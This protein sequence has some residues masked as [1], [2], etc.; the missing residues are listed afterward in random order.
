ME[1]QNAMGLDFASVLKESVTRKPID[2]H[3]Q[4]FYPAKVV[5]NKD[6]DKLGRCRVMV[7]GVYDGIP[8]DSLPWA[9]PDFGFI[10]SAIGSFT[11]PPVDAI[12][13]VYFDGGD[14]YLPKY[15]TKVLTPSAIRNMVSDIEEDYPNTMV[16]FETDNGDYFRINRSANSMEL[17]H[18]SGS[19]IRIDKE[20]NMKIFAAN[21]MEIR[22]DGE[23][24]LNAKGNVSVYGQQIKLPSKDGTSQIWQPN[25]CPNCLFT[26]VPHGGNMAGLMGLGGSNV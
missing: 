18:S 8:T 21:N 11:V 3:K 19:F 10:G 12:V 22:S 26:G 16:L 9:I 15:T 13:N 4:Q 25:V 7:F 24:V 23:M 17:Q 6:P 20:G 1:V 5:D 2:E 14:T